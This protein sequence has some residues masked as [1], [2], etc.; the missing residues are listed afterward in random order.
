[1]GFLVPD[2]IGLQ[3][4]DVLFRYRG[5]SLPK[6]LGA[7]GVGDVRVVD[8]VAVGPFKAQ[9]FNAGIQFGL[10]GLLD[11]FEVFTANGNAEGLLVASLGQCL[12]D[13]VCLA[14]PAPATDYQEVIQPRWHRTVPPPMGC[15][16]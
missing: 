11:A 8:G 4:L 12:R 6:D 13:L 16:G 5:Q 1:M 3:P 9:L 14:G 2:N 7:V 10:G 15:S